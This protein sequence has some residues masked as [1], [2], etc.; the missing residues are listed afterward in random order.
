[1]Y[2]GAKKQEKFMFMIVNR[3]G[4]CFMFSRLMV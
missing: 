2:I 1:M 4:F 3:S